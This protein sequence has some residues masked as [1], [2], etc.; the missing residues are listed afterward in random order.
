[1]LAVKINIKFLPVCHWRNHLPIVRVCYLKR[2]K[3][4]LD[5]YIHCLI[6]LK[7]SIFWSM[8]V[9]LSHYI[10]I[11][12]LCFQDLMILDVYTYCLLFWVW[13]LH[14]NVN[15]IVL[16]YWFIFR[17]LNTFAQQMILVKMKT[18]EEVFCRTEKND[19]MQKHL[20]DI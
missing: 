5:V 8:V 12:I 16:I 7:K 15:I 20:T 14:I 17:S 11:V 9:H 13:R 6:S 3:S 4:W 10:L 18:L 2:F 19:K 1:M